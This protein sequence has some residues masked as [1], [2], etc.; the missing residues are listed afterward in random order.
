MM[1]G[2][3]FLIGSTETIGEFFCCERRTTSFSGF[4]SRK[5]RKTLIEQMAVVMYLYIADAWYFC[6]PIC[7]N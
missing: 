2:K 6:K 7:K 4:S 3:L 1:T 5:I